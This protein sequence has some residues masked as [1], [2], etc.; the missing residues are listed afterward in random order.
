[1]A[2]VTFQSPSITAPVS[3]TRIMSSAVT[4][5]QVKFRESIFPNRT[6]TAVEP[7]VPTLWADIPNEYGYMDDPD[8][9]EDEFDDLEPID[10]ISTTES[11]YEE[12]SGEHNE[13]SNAES[14]EEP[15]AQ[16]DDIPLRRV[17]PR[18]AA[19]NGSAVGE[20]LNHHALDQ[21]RRDGTI[22]VL[23][24][25]VTT[26]DADKWSPNRFE[27]IGSISDVDLQKQWYEAHYKENDGLFDHPDVLK[28]V[29]YP[30]GMKNSDLMRLHTIYTVKSDGRK[31][32][33]TVLGAGKDKLG[34]L[35]LGY[36]RSFSPTARSTTVRLLCALAAAL[37]LTIRGGDVTQAFIQGEWPAHIKKVHAH[38]PAGYQKY[39]NGVPYCCEV[40]NL[41]GH[42]IAGRNW[43][44]KFRKRMIF[45]GYIQ[46]EHDPCLFYK[47]KVNGKGLFLLIVYVD[48]ILTFSSKQSIY[49]EWL[50]W[51]GREFVWSNFD[52][53]LQEF[54]SIGI[55]QTHGDQG[56][57]TLDMNRYIKDMVDEHFPAGIHHHYSVPADTDLTD[58]VY[59]AS[60]VKDTS[61]SKTELGKR[62]RRLCM[63]LLYCSY[64]ARPDIS[65]S[66]GLLTRVQ[67]YPSP[68]LLKRAE[69][70]LIYLAGT[71]DV[72]LTYTAQGNTTPT[73][74]WAPRVT[75]AGA[76]DASFA[77]AHSTSGFAFF[78][79]GAAIQWS[80][81]KQQTIALST[82]EAEVVAGSMAACSAVAIRGI[83]EEIGFEQTEP[84]KLSMDS[85]SAIDLAND[86]MHYDKSKHIARRDLFIRELVENEIIKTH[87]IA[88]TKNPSDML[89]KPLNKAAFNVHRATMMGI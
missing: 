10:D 20:L 62:F 89:T 47:K 24:T 31:K 86:P 78:M 84:T 14:N 29:P 73:G 80:S 4:S 15:S 56:K 71:P 1:M 16:P 79:S 11:V 34:E 36:E 75:V 65:I 70:V 6:Y 68:E 45:H 44:Q 37:D 35:D 17:S 83:L 88:T 25:K 81:K 5:S 26:Q 82:Y 19:R 41:Y 18:L 39:I 55:S 59:K 69:R 50:A 23:T 60:C 13:E 2:G 48:D 27:Q 64:Q 54:T 3:S 38:M 30:P 42:P 77:V 12:S 21:G 76:A 67:A 66:I 85:S 46:S 8:D 43:F 51:F 58:F 40:G 87:F 72:K 9:T 7:D 32:A 63:Q 57:V 74:A 28:M 52:V 33:R 22:R 49:Q 61:Y 53:N